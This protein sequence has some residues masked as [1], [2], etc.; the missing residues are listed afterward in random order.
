MKDIPMFTTEYGIASLALKEIPYRQ[1]AYIIIQASEEPEKLL[2]ECVSFCRMVG[3]EKIYARGHAFLE[4][5]PLHCDV[6]EM[7]G[8]IP[9]DD[10]KVR[11][12]WPVTEQT[13][14]KWRSLMNARLLN[15]DNAAT[16][17]RRDEK[18]ILSSGGVYFVHD[19]GALLGGGW[20]DGGEVK[21]IAAVKK[22][23]GECVLHTLLSTAPERSLWLQVASTNTTAIRFYERMG[24]VKT[25]LVS[26]WYR[27]L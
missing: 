12:L 13:V 3:A 17:E 25:A 26:R 15:V 14:E 19:N 8:D 27:I 6:L 20:I 22:G 18:E 1:E 21:L 16:L 23:A 11:N 7:R 9:A 4:R 24:L 2:Q 10:E 5:Y